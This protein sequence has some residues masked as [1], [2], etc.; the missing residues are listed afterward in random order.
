MSGSGHVTHEGLASSQLFTQD[1]GFALQ[2]NEVYTTWNALPPFQETANVAS[3]QGSPFPQD[4]SVLDWQDYS[5]LSNDHDEIY[6]QGA[7]YGQQPD[8]AGQTAE[9]TSLPGFVGNS[10]SPGTVSPQ[11]LLNRPELGESSIDEKVRVL[12][13]FI[14][15]L[16]YSTYNVRSS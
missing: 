5:S 9:G 8:L 4:F 7:V 6:K 3:Q 10:S 12:C 13:D 14:Y 1:P 11:A 16:S 2:H 15:Q